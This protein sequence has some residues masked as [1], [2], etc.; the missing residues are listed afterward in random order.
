MPFDKEG[1]RM[2]IPVSIRAL[3]T[4][5]GLLSFAQEQDDMVY[6]VSHPKGDHHISA[7]NG[8]LTP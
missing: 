1:D 8:E 4:M 2:T 3:R 5:G 7:M 6:R